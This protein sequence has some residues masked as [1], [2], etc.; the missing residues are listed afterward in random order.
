MTNKVRKQTLRQRSYQLLFGN[1]TR[2]GRRMQ[3]FWVSSAL[4]SV[5]LLFLEPGGS[6]VYTRN[7][8]VLHQLLLAEVFFTVIFTAEYLLRLWC[9]PSKERYAISFF[10]I[11]DLLTMLPMYIIWLFP[12]MAVEYVVLLR[13][14]R[15]LR[16]LRVLK[17]LRYMSE[18]G[19]VWRSIKLARHKLAM[20]F[21]F[22]GVMLCV[23]G[24]LMYAVE[25]GAGGFTSLAASMYWAVVTL[26]TVGYGDI[27]PHTALGRMLA[28]V[29][30][31]VGYSI[32]AV[33][34]GILTAY[35]SQEMRR[36]REERHCVQCDCG[37]HETEAKFCKFCGA[38]LPPL[39]VKSTR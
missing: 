13:V 31:L 23:F 2:I 1:Q 38:A 16:V 37:G 17:L 21:G 34:T 6:S 7:A 39:S 24:G 33:P 4:L 3:L 28:S 35:M 10:G 32:I 15:I 19:I 36:Y 18:M 11:V 20:F 9:T 22:V 30:I 27:V 5:L 12:H 29:L 26:T 8:Q 25:G 14:L